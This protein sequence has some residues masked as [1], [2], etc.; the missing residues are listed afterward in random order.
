M[1]SIVCPFIT[2]KLWQNINGKESVHLQQFPKVEKGKINLKLEKEMKLV[3]KIIE[4]GLAER[5][6]AGIGLKW[7]LSMAEITTYNQIP[8]DLQ[9]IIIRQLNVKKIEIKKAGKGK[10][11]EIKVQLDTKITPELEAEGF[12][13][14]LSRKIQAERKNKG[15][16]K[17]DK[18]NLEILTDKNSVDKLKKFLNFIKNRTNSEKINIDFN[19]PKF[20]K[21][22]VKVVIK[23]IEF[24]IGFNKV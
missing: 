10:S 16:V 4:A 23:N 6:K 2:E 1:F 3:L 17:S 7:P 5:D 13:R 15:L 11:K 18:I 19:L 22:F 21:N 20:K 12:A 8:K 24:N 14:E 9:K